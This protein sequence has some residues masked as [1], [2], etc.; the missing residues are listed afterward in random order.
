MRPADIISLGD[1]RFGVEDAGT[2][3]IAYAAVDGRRTWVFL[4]GHVHVVDEPGAGRPARTAHQ[5][6]EMAL[7]SPMPATVVDVKRNAGDRVARGD[8]ILV[9][10]AMKME[11][12]IRA[13]RD[14]VIT[15]LHCQ[16][17]DLVQPGRPLAEI[18]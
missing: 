9:L 6:D 2:R 18:A 4:D 14:G 7:A 15:A 16:K 11:L 12:P 8:V 10:E 3:R 1:G 13:P 5:D 17:G